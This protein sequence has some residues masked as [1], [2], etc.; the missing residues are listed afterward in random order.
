M[1]A[2]LVSLLVNHGSSKLFAVP[3]D[4][5]SNNFQ[6]AEKT[7][8]FYT[9]PCLQRH[10]SQPP[11]LLP[12]SG[13]VWRRNPIRPSPR[14]IHPANRWAGKSIVDALCAEMKEKCRSSRPPGTASSR[15][16]PREQDRRDHRLHVEEPQAPRSD[17]VLQRPLHLGRRHDGHEEW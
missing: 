2:R 11:R 10:S 17:R 15:R 16:S 14:K 12:T 13:S 5:C 1:A 7:M 9:F 8:N 6:I 4:Q 3:Q